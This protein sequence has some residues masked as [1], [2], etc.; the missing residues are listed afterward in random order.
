[1]AVSIGRWSRQ[2][3]RVRTPCIPQRRASIPSCRH[4]SQTLALFVTSL[5]AWAGWAGPKPQPRRAPTQ[6]LLQ[7]SASC[8]Y[9]CNWRRTAAD[10]RVCCFCLMTTSSFCITDQHHRYRALLVNGNQRRRVRFWRRGCLSGRILQNP[11]LYDSVSYYCTIQ[12]ILLLA[13]QNI[14]DSLIHA[15]CLSLVCVLT[16]SSE[17][18]EIRF[19]RSQKS[20]TIQDLFRHFLPGRGDVRPFVGWG[21]KQLVF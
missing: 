8:F 2:H 3:V 11:Y 17:T 20:L 10:W 7:F 14:F 5:P 13:T 4:T 12:C 9:K 16:L 18:C 19:T 15:Q 21:P 6:P 1:M